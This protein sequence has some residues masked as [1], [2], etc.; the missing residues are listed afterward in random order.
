LVHFNNFLAAKSHIAET[1]LQSLTNGKMNVY[2]LLD[3]FLGDQLEKVGKKTAILHLAAIRSYL[4]F[5]D[6]DITP[7]RFKKR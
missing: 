6:I 1:I 3:L 5:Q 4:E 2:E 7:R